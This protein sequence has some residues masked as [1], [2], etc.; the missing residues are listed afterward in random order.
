MNITLFVPMYEGRFVRGR[1]S[2]W[3]AATTR[4]N[5]FQKKVEVGCRGSAG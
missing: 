5:G 2:H 4:H 3:F 1:D